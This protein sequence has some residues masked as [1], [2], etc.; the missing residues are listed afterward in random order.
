MPLPDF[1]QHWTTFLGDD[2]LFPG[3]STVR[4]FLRS[5]TSD[6]NTPSLN[7]VSAKHLISPC[8]SSLCK[9]PDSS[10]PDRQVCIDSY[11]EEK[12]GLIDHEVYKKIF[13]NQYLSLRR[14]GKI[15]KSIPSMCV[16]V[17]KNDKYG[18]PLRAKSRIVVLGNFE[19]RIYQKSQRYAPL[20][21]YSSLRL[22]TAKAVG[23][24]RILQK[25]DCKNAFCNAT[26][27]D[28][29]VTFIR[30]TIGNPSFQE[31][32]YWLLKK[33]LYGL[34]QSPHHWY[35]II[36]GILLKMGIKASPH[37]PCLL[38]GIIEDPNSQKTISEYQYQLHVGLYVEDFVFY[39]SDPYQEALFK[40]LLQ[41]HIQVDFMG[42]VDY[43]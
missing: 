7:Y 27:L 28:N 14:S 20:L 43:F 25:V 23:D 37:D 13:K 22:L 35:N 2:R 5:A 17:V 18:K 30:P 21:K 32:E 6:K 31:D 3:H 36:K 1:K 4:S 38:S 10:N 9:A 34:C 41:E 16:L 33:T 24:K 42:D 29:E 40:N 11:K 26:L 8:P 12:Q 15:P 19:D 39:S